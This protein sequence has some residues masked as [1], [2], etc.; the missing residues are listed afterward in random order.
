MKFLINRMMTIF[1]KKIDKPFNQIV[2]G[3]IGAIKRK[4]ASLKDGE[5]M[6]T[7]EVHS[8]IA[9]SMYA[10]MSLRSGT[11][12]PKQQS[13]TLENF[14]FLFCNNIELL[15]KDMFEH[16]DNYNEDIP[17]GHAMGNYDRAMN[18]K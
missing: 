6:S 11:T 16:M 12:L 15:D 9:A 18:D 4:Q 17:L 14:V 10:G 7:A 1:D 5:K 3:H 2:G 8:A 13:E